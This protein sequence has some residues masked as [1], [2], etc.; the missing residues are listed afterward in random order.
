[1][2]LKLPP[3][4]AEMLHFA[5]Q[6]FLNKFPDDLEPCRLQAEKILARHRKQHPAPTTTPTTP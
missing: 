1:M 3:T 6:G 4:A 5:Y 2:N